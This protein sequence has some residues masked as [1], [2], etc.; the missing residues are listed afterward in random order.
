MINN[1]AKYFTDQSLISNYLNQIKSK[2]PR[3]TRDHL[4]VIL[5]TLKRNNQ[6]EA[7]DNTLNFC[8]KND[9]LSGYEFEQVYYVLLNEIEKSK[10]VEKPEIKLLNEASLKKAE[11]T[12]QTSNIEDYE[13]IINL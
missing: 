2:Y 6:K 9:I 4:Y 13:D 3:Y 12:P 11:Q 7:A 5:K 8:L 10:T 1:T